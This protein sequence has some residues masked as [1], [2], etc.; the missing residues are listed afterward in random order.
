RFSFIGGAIQPSLPRL[1][2]INRRY[3]T[4]EMRLS[5]KDPGNDKA[6]KRQAKFKLRAA[7]HG[8]NFKKRSEN[9][10]TPTVQPEMKKRSFRKILVANRGEIALRVMRSCHAMGIETVTVYSDAD[11][12]SPHVR[13]AGEAVHLGAAPAQESYLRIEKVIEA[14][15]RTIA[16]AI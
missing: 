9:E 6:L 3:A 2:K 11:A 14:A 1:G 13:F 4:K 5:C 15:K 12:D 10:R 7:A 8:R 16:D